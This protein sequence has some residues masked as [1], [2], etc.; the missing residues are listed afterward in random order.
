MPTLLAVDLGLR[1]GLA[2]YRADGRLVS[3]RSHNFGAPARLRKGAPT[4]LAELPDLEIVVI[5]GGGQLAEIWEK[6]VVRR[7]LCLIQIDAETWR[8]KLLYAR[9]QRSGLQAKQHA[10]DLARRVIAWSE[11]PRP[12]ALRHD[13]AEAILIGLWGVL[14]VGWLERV[15]PEVRR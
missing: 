3:Y 1:T 2:I 8:E 4:V 12:T 15:P 5:E 10:D 14:E 11:A 9:E 7:G 6:A 13:A